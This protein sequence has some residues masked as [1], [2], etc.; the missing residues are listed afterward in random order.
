MSEETGASGMAGRRKGM[1]VEQ[2]VK[3]KR[4]EQTGRERNRQ[5]GKGTDRKGKEQAGI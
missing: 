4:E 3:R 2:A 1:G 5:E